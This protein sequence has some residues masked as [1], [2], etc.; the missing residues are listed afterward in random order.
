VKEKVEKDF[1]LFCSVLHK[2]CIMA[3]KY[4]SPKVPDERQTNLMK[5]GCLYLVRRGIGRI[6]CRW[7]RQLCSWRKF[8]FQNREYKYFCHSYNETW[9]NERAVEI[10]MIWNIVKSQKDN[11]LEIGNVLSHYFP[12]PHDILDKYEKAKGVVNEDVVDFKTPKRYDLIVSISTLEH[13]GWDESPKDGKKILIAID[14]LKRLLNPRGKVVI[15]VPIGYN[16]Y[17]DNLLKEN[18]T[19]FTSRFCLKRISKNNL[20]IETDWKGVENSKF[21]N[22][23][24]FANGIVI[25]IIET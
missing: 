12:L 24:P 10:P 17:L 7:S 14:G 11:I 23:Y 21:N 25:G 15:S 13:V 9:Q 19:G 22:P 2:I 1:T 3:P 6:R 16:P 4:L 8:K 18:K 20:W 5:K